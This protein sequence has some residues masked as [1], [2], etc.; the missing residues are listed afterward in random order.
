[1]HYCTA[2]LAAKDAFAV[3]LFLF[4]DVRPILDNV[5]VVGEQDGAVLGVQP[6]DFPSK[7]G[8][9]QLGDFSR[10]NRFFKSRE[11]MIMPLKSRQFF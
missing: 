5:S 2:W 1:M 3:K 6:S 10:E 8:C 11:H 7:S 4:K 9:G